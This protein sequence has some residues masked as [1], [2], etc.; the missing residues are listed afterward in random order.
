MSQEWYSS[1]AE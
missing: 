1:G